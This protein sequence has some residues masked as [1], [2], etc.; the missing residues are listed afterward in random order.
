[1]SAWKRLSVPALLGV[2]LACVAPSEKSEAASDLRCLGCHPAIVRDSVVHKPVGGGECVSCH[3]MVQGKMH[4]SEKGSATLQEKGEKLCYMCHDNLAGKKFVHGPVASG[5]CQACH[6][7][8]KSPNPKLLKGTGADFCFMCHENKF[9]FKYGH[10]PVVQGDCLACHDPH[11]SDSKMMVRKPGS[12]LCFDCHDS[13]IAKGKSV[14]GPVATGDCLGCHMVH[15]SPYRHM[16]KRDNPD[17][18]YM[19]YSPSH[20]SFCFDCH[21]RE[22]AKDKRTDTLTGFRNGD[23]NLHELHV[24]KPDKGRTCKTCHE[25]HNSV[26]GR[27]LKKSIPG[28]GK[29]DIPMFFTGTTTGGTC[30]VGCHKPKSY[31]RLRPVIN[32]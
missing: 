27:L 29:W 18:Y 20:Y 17:L 11:Q 23:R 19:P 1:M 25:P 6:E 12:K 30:V 31:D 8:H 26:Q 13:A 22:L 28:F 16:L 10:A 14:H 4:P 9:Q 2:L 24:N 7:V 15:G 3:L 21:N 5:E 32:P